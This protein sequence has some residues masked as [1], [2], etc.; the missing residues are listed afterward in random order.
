MRSVLLFVLLAFS[1]LANST[2]TSSFFLPSPNELSGVPFVA[3]QG[4]LVQNILFVPINHLKR[5]I[6]SELNITLK[7]RGEAHITV[8]SPPEFSDI[9]NYISMREIN[10]LAQEKQLQTMPFTTTCVGTRALFINGILEQPFYV[11]VKS[12]ALVDFR[13]LILKT[14]K[15]KGYVGSD[16][17]PEIYFPHITIGYKNRDLH[18]QDGVIKDESSCLWQLF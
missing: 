15:E 18:A 4:Y 16:F 7:D 1:L 6:E 17:D 3:N 11:V 13:H 10:E 9:K 12:Q 14:V 5:V 8:I 2:N